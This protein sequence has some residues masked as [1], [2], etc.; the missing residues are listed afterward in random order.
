MYCIFTEI[1]KLLGN[2]S[3]YFSP[4]AS[5]MEMVESYLKDKKRIL[6]CAALLEG[7]YGISGYYIG[8][9]VL[10]GAGGI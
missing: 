2:G 8:V 10:I 4:A 7:E 3:A 5:I 9:P 1:V 6:P